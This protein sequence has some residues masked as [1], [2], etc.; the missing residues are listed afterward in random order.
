MLGECLIV[1]FALPEDI[2]TLLTEG[3]GISWGRG[4]GGGVCKTK[5][6]KELYE[7]SYNLNFQRGGG[8]SL[9]I[10]LTCQLEY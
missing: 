10:V 1:N 9:E 6:I 5:K 2:H 8:K 4:G 7:A 3:I